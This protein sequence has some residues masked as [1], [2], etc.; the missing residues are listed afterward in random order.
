MT[1]GAA[2]VTLANLSRRLNDGLW[3]CFFRAT[4]F[5]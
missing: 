3:Y 1:G 4:T 5:S 2:S